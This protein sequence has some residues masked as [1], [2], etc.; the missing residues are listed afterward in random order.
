MAAF[1]AGRWIRKTGPH[2]ARTPP[3]GGKQGRELHTHRSGPYVS[4]LDKSRIRFRR[5][6][7]HTYS[8]E[9]GST[10]VRNPRYPEKIGRASCRERV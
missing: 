10:S 8:K 4:V 1:R 7:G 9:E 2:R 5:N 3:S 6:D